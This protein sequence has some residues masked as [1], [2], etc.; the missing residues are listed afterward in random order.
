M[1]FQMKLRLNNES[2]LRIFLNKYAVCQGIRNINDVYYC[3]ENYDTQIRIRTI[4]N[5]PFFKL[6]IKN[7]GVPEEYKMMIEDEF[8][9]KKILDVFGI[10]K[11]IIVNKVRKNWLYEDYIISC[12]KVENLDRFVEI[13]HISRNTNEDDIENIKKFIKTFSKDILIFKK[14]YDE[15][16]EA[17]VDKYLD[18]SEPL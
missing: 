2:K 13:E 16:V 15:L 6:G 17:G 10:Q 12:D 4:D 18:Y 1:K 3:N 9:I 8:V 11:R 5:M 14:G 7:K